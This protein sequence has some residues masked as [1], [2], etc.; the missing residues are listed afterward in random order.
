MMNEF[1]LTNDGM[2]WPNQKSEAAL[3]E[4]A[5]VKHV[6]VNEVAYKQAEA[7]YFEAH[8]QIEALEEQTIK[9]LTGEN[10]ANFNHC[11]KR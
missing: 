6:S 4:K 9:N 2:T 5:K 7:D 1:A 3:L 11:R 8:K 10:T